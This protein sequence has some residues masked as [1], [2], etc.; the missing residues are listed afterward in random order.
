MTKPGPTQSVLLG[1]TA[2]KEMR[3]SDVTRILVPIKRGPR[4]SWGVRYVIQKHRTGK[5]VEV[6]LLNVSEPT[7]E[8]QALKYR[9]QQQIAQIHKQLAEVL[10]EDAAQPLVVAGIPY[11]GFFRHGPLVVSILD[12]AEELGCHEIAVPPPKKGLAALFSRNVVR[13][14]T[15]QERGIPVLTVNYGGFPIRTA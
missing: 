10:I 11:W 14:L 3:Q 1:G 6:V 8:W 9:T 12:A 7:T 13:E 5:P 15:K 2:N 4:S